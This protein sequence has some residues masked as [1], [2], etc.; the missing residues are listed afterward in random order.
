MSTLAAFVA[1]ALLS[2]PT[3]LSG[4]QWSPDQQEVVAH[5]DE[6]ITVG[7]HIELHEAVGAAGVVIADNASAL[8]VSD[9]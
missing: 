6:I 8:C 7:R 5:F 3:P 4:Q 1:V 2:T 9:D